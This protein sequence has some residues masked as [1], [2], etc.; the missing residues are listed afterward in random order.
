MQ[1][2]QLRRARDSPVSSS[3][4]PSAAGSG[5][6][7]KGFTSGAVPSVGAGTGASLDLQLSASQ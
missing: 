4:G 1:H 3:L 2:L 5:S 7:S 6:Y